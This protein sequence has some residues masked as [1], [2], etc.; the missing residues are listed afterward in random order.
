M[1]D[2]VK[3]PT[4]QRQQRRGPNGGWVYKF[5]KRLDAGSIVVIAEVKKDVCWLVTVYRE[6][7]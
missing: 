6:N 3:Y 4:A 1:K 2:V 7:L 5:T